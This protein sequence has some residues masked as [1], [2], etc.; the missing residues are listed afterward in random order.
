MRFK[1]G[2]EVNEVSQEIEEGRMKVMRNEGRTGGEEMGVSWEDQTL[3]SNSRGRME[4]K[5]KQMSSREFE[6]K[7]QRRRRVE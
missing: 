4:E 3:W 7:K 1:V 6:E 2:I 5:E